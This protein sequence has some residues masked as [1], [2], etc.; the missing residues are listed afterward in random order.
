MAQLI[1]R[2]PLRLLPSTLFGR[3]ALLLFVAVLA[4]HA[5]ALTLMFE[6]R[7]PM[8][9]PG[10][11]MTPDFGPGHPPPGPPPLLHPGLLLDIGVRL[12]A[13]MLAAWIGA[14]WL[15]QPI[16][17]LASAAR[18]IGLDVHRSP[19]AEEGTEECRAATRVFN[20][21][22]AQICQQLSERDRFVAA[23]SHDLRTP[24]T[25]LALR[26]E[27]LS[28]TLQ[29]QQFG[30]DIVEMNNMITATLDYLR[31]AADPEP[32]VL[33]DVMSLLESLADDQQAC[34]HDVTVT[35]YAEPLRAQAS[36][37]RRCI[38]NLVANAV[39]YGHV[40][41]ISLTDHPEHVCIEVSDEG[42]GIPEDEL[43]RVLAPFYRVEASRNRNSGG[44]G[45]GLSIAHNI[46][47]RHQGQLRLRNGALAG[48]IV[49]LT[50]PR[51]LAA[52]R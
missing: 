47:R 30:K 11:G 37:L 16:R 24:L 23:V 17:R 29:R 15:S 41:R 9:N 21:M 36:S 5:L 49:T 2:F 33:L 35:G 48:L 40:A 8:P 10:P 1:A 7:P 14:R 46:T 39:R 19:L 26:A 32:L 6:L 34:G 4:S 51:R 38:D 28:D 27:G 50:L 25:R 3:L 43:D 18:E 31:G 22:Q 52:D 20:Q 42:P 45:L 44:V 13:L 12:S